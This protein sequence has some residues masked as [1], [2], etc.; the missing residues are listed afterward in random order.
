MDPVSTESHL[1]LLLKGWAWW[2]VIPLAIGAGWLALKMARPETTNL[3]K[4]GR[5]LRVLRAAVAVLLVIFLGQPVIQTLFPKYQ[6]PRVVLLV[7]RSAS[8]EVRDTQETLEWKVRAAAA[9][10]LF[11]EKLRDTNAEQAAALLRQAQ[12]RAETAGAALRLA[13]QAARESVTDA[14][15]AR[16]RIKD[17]CAALKQ[18]GQFSEQALA[19][20]K[21]MA[22]A[23]QELSIGIEKAV[24]EAASLAKEIDETPLDTAGAGDRLQDKLRLVNAHRKS[25]TQLFSLAARTQD[26]ADR[27][28]GEKNEPVIREALTKLNGMNRMEITEQ[29]LTR[30]IKPFVNEH[31]VAVKAYYLD[32]DLQPAPYLQ[33]ALTEGITK[34]D[35]VDQKK[36][37]TKEETEERE[38]VAETDLATPLFRLAEREGQESLAAVVL[39]SDGRHTTGPLPEDAARAMA[40][41]GVKLHALGVGAIKSPADICVARLEGPISVF[42]DETIRLTAHL[43]GV[44]YKD[45]EVKLVL[46]RGQEVLQERGIKFV[47]EEWRQEVFEVPASQSGA[48]LFIAS[49]EPLEGEALVLNN[50]AEALVD[51]ASDKLRVLVIDEEPRWETRYVASLLRRE[52]K[53]VLDERWLRYGQGF[54]KSTPALPQEPGKLDEYD[55]VVLGDIPSERL[56]DADQKRLANY[57]SDRGGFLVILAG[58]L[59]MPQKYLTGPVAELLPIRPFSSITEGAGFSAVQGNQQGTRVKLFDPVHPPEITQILRDPS[60]NEQLWPLLPELK[61]V[62]RPSSAKPGAVPLLITDDVRQDVVAATQFF[63]LGRVLYLGTDETWRWRH[64]VGDRVHAYFWS[65]AIRWGVS[66]R[67][68]GDKRLKVGVDRRRIR[69]G[70][71]IEVLARPAD[72]KGLPVNDAIVVAEVEFKTGRKRVQLEP[73]AD[74]RGLYRGEIQDLP[75]G[76]HNV[77]VHVEGPGF[78]DV[79][80]EV[81]V[82]AREAAG[83]EG[84]ELTRDVDRLNSMAQSGGGVC[85]DLLQA[86]ELLKTISAEGKYQEREESFELWSS[87]PALLLVVG[88]LSAEWLLRKRYGLA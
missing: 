31:K 49:I 16:A 3:G 56:N 1:S 24:K 15:A 12:G 32:T 68:T 19:K 58:Q 59:A 35:A 52:R 25:L 63:G 80:G 62:H 17:V 46:K 88:L 76:L 84:V 29:L 77:V 82:M 65:Q 81:Q 4:G 44:G 69:P 33:A 22:A 57:V 72:A 11:D 14:A 60:L 45:R 83:Q 64:K 9:V 34:A 30:Q 43:R 61:F 13:Q 39:C 8:M 37:A 78:Q 41:R 53:M 42:K 75:S 26:L 87:Y 55:M 47:N 86:G 2:V 7:D 5:W 18:T 6:E 27:A 50:S 23:P 48:N 71:K 38:K 85:M 70:E 10:G 73:V 51:V 74:S 21:A 79:K 20:A 67:L 36:P 40:A 54:D 66:Q 28:L